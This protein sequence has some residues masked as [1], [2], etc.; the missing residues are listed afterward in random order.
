[1]KK[2]IS[3]LIIL[4]L[5]TTV[6]SSKS[7]IDISDKMLNYTYP[8]IN[9]LHTVSIEVGTSQN[10]EPCHNWSQTIYEVYTSGAYDFEYVEYI[11]YDLEGKKL[12]NEAY[13]WSKDYDIGKVPTSV[14]D[15]N[16]ER[17]AGDNPELLPEA[18]NSCGNREVAD[19]N[20]YI[21]V[22]WLGD[23]TIQVEISIENNEQYQYN[24]HIRASITEIISRYNTFNG[25]PYHF[26][27]LDFAFNKEIS[28]DA[29]GL[30]TDSTTWNG[31]E[32]KDNQENDFGDIDPDNIQVTMC[33]INESNGFV[34][35]TVMG[36]IIP[37]NPPNEPSNPSPLEGEKDIEIDSD[38]SWE[39]SDPDGGLLKYDIYLGSNNPPEQ[40]VW[41]QTMKSY[42]PGTMEYN[43]TYYWK[44][45]AFDSHGASTS[46]PIWSF[47]T[48]VKKNKAPTVVI[49]RPLKALYIF[50]SYIMPR[51]FRLTKVI[52]KITLEADVKDEDSNIDKVEFFINGELKGTDDTYPY[53]YDLTWNRLRF[54]HLFFIKVI[55]YDTDGAS[56]TSNIIIRK[57]L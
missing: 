37:N 18:I 21:T 38:L 26:G 44:I 46:G 20:G 36:R 31:S 35:E 47:T 12:N 45:V 3:L 40:I 13:N 56:D 48:K 29:G 52:G 10:C 19:I 6:V 5:F 25:E 42:D 11:I 55:A 9:F 7:A 54:I 17:I 15:G 14:L 32:H 53:T 30:F 41:N 33:I 39:C 16:F 43:K 34:D 51:F 50:N 23:A 8:N 49:S 24:G 1:M 28:I 27:F 57:F 22:L 2:Y 4:L